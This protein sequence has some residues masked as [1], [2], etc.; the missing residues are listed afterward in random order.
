MEQA[1]SDV[2]ILDFSQLLQ[3]P[4]ATQMLGDMGANVIKVERPV[5]GDLFRSMTFNNQWVGG[6][7]SPNFLAWNRNKRSIAVN[8]K[9]EESIAILYRLVEQADIVVENFRPGVMDRLGYGYDD[10]KAINPK[11]IY[12]SGTG[13]GDS[14][15]YVER[16]GQ[17]MLVQGLTGLMAATGQASQPPTPAGSGF[18][19]QVGA[20]NIVYSVLS[21]L[22]W[23]ER[24]GKGQ[25]IV[26]NLL[27][28][29]L[30]HQGQEMLMAMNFNQDFQ[31]PNSGIGHPGMDAPFGT[32]PTS[33]GWV[34][35]AMSP[36]K[37][38]VKVLGDDSLLK[39]DDPAILFD[40]RD[41]IWNEIA[42]RTQAFDTQTLMS[43]MLAEDIWCGEVKSHLEA[44]DDPQVKH[45]GLIQE[46][47]HS[48]A[49]SVKCVGPA[50]SM[51]ET[52]PTIQ[53]SAPTVGEHTK[54]VLAE[55]GFTDQEITDALASGSI[56]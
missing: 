43:M 46:Y 26:V 1:L 2:T 25:K 48:V 28:G 38:L 39:Y 35:I 23:R 19:D 30:A 8:L 20:M 42:K 18:S 13:Y 29:M 21:A 37:T 56:A 31:R 11:L 49:G 12:C 9:S 3:G 40:Q 45:L 34:T 44:A 14:G 7:E 22:Y 17:D 5:S 52:Q 32:Y 53:R 4:F 10:L 15:P 50:V 33:D 16:P 36:F 51:S 6:K 24:S 55:F 54:E 27:A 47:Q 41:I